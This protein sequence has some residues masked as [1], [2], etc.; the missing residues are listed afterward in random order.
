MAQQTRITSAPNLM[1]TV[2]DSTV[3][4]L[5]ADSGPLSRARIAELTGISKPTVLD[6]V[7]RLSR[8]K[9]IEIVGQRQDSTPGPR[10][11][12]YSIGRGVGYGVGIDIKGHGVAVEIQN[13]ARETV[14]HLVRNLE[15]HETA[16][17]DVVAA[18]REGLAIAGINAVDVRVAAIGAPG[19]VDPEA[20]DISAFDLPHWQENLGDCLRQDLD[21]TLLYDNEVNLRALAEKEFGVGRGVEDF[22]LLALG[23][24]IGAGII[25]GGRLHRGRRGFA[26]ELG[27]LPLTVE[28]LTPLGETAAVYER[29]LQGRIGGPAILELA[30]QSGIDTVTESDAVTSAVALLEGPSESDV[31]RADSFLNEL[32]GRIALALAPAYVLLS[33]E[34][35]V[36]AGEVGIAGGTELAARVRQKLEYVYANPPEVLASTIDNSAVLS[37]AMVLAQKQLQE[38]AF[39][40]LG[41]NPAALAT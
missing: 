41:Y 33:P 36:L 18:V 17:D 32:A 19:I 25:L 3:F 16:V 40:R 29:G 2:N 15:T 23:Q 20:G 22:V 8:L 39:L 10:A 27:F 30:A 28:E 5:L 9:M 38:E 6:I 7:D 24:G 34:L 4:S 12:L 21:C 31:H 11:A 37:G 1:R 14:A 35:F 26:G 13:A